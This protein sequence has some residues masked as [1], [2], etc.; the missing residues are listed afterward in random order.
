MLIVVALEDQMVNPRPS[1]EFARLL[2]APTLELE[3]DC[4]HLA[5]GCE[6]KHLAAKVESFL[7]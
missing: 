4:G 5:P 6:E 7:K 1:L 3:S 2:Q